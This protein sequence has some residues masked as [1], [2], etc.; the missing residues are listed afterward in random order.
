MGTTPPS[1]WSFRG[2]SR[3]A[4]SQA[5][6][7]TYAPCVHAHLP[8]R[9]C[10][11]GRSLEKRHANTKGNVH[12]SPSDLKQ[13]A[14]SNPGIPNANC[15]NTPPGEDESA[16]RRKYRSNGCGMSFLCEH[17][18]PKSAVCVWLVSKRM[19]HNACVCAGRM[20][21]YMRGS[22]DGT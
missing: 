2:C 21:T 4:P 17:V 3:H 10:A 12:E 6:A 8:H 19:P 11:P 15:P 18:F 5:A 22:D 1:A 9:H 13:M 16:T 7:F 20:Q 14:T